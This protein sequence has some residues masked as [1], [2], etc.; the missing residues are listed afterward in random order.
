MMLERD[1][2]SSH[3]TRG[4]NLIKNCFYFQVRSVSMYDKKA[5]K[6]L[7]PYRMECQLKSRFL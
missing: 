3:V 2:L 4:K 6:I 5:L 1:I 7:K